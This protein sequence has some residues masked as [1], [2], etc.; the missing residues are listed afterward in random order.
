M[1]ASNAVRHCAYTVMALHGCIMSEIQVPFSFCHV[2]TLLDRLL[3]FNFSRSQAPPEKRRVF[4]E[5]LQEVS[6]EGA[7]VLRELGSKIDKMEKLGGFKNIL[8]H[9]HVAAEHLQK[10]IDHKSFLLVNSESWEVGSP[11]KDL[12][13]LDDPPQQ[14]LGL[15]CLSETSIYAHKAQ[16]QLP[17][18]D[19]PP[20]QNLRRLVPWPSSFC[21]VESDGV[22]VREDEA[23]TYE[24]A[25]SLSLA[26]F[27]S[28]L[29]EFV[30]RLQIVVDCFEELSEEAEFIDPDVVVLTESGGQWT[31][32]VWL[33]I[34][35][36]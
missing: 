4:Y 2:S 12:E 5:E 25:S 32:L 26:T 29:I 19:F 27:A 10:K 17:D 1:K 8:D 21:L 22:L 3:G 20:M 24:S 11:R 6:T 14:H 18:E 33:Q 34:F 28:L 36:S 7:R 9:V 31:R 13:E 23:K 16:S 15:K 30:A 35:E